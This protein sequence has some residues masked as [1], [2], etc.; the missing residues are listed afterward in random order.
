MTNAERQ[1]PVSGAGLGLRRGLIDHLMAE[2]HNDID[3]MELNAVITDLLKRIADN[4]KQQ[5]DRELL[6]D[7][8]KKIDFDSDALVQ[9]GYEALR[10]MRASNIIIGTIK[11]NISFGI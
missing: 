5:S 6:I 8:T 11:T 9:Y 10:E 4:P 2:P 1:D 3:F 7:L